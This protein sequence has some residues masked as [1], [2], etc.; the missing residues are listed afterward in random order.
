MA[1][2]MTHYLGYKLKSPIILSSGPA[3]KDSTCLIKAVEAG[4]GAVTTP[5]IR[6]E[7]MV[8]PL[9]NLAAVCGGN[10]MLNSQGHSDVSWEDW[11]KI[12][13]PETKKSGA[14][15]IAKLGYSVEEVEFLAPKV[16]AAGADV[17]EIIAPVSDLMPKMV[18][19]AKANTQLPVTAKISGRWAD[20]L[21]VA[22]AC[23]E[24]GAKAITAIDTIGPAL[25]IDIKTGRPKLGGTTRHGTGFGWLSG[26]AIHP[27]AVATVAHIALLRRV[28]VIGIGG[29]SDA[30]SAL[31]MIMAGATAVGLQTAV[32]ME[33]PSVITTILTE[34]SSLLETLGYDSLEQARGISLPYLSEEDTGRDFQIML[35]KEACKDCARNEAC[36][37]VCPYGVFE[38]PV[39]NH[40]EC[41]LECPK[42][43]LCVTKCSGEGLKV[44]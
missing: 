36:P 43:G 7:Q 5:S 10:S 15:V 1:D 4:V 33:G 39:Y 27:I 17:I 23:I 44:G 29:I 34:L 31:E 16:T 37:V 38:P 19:V 26:E 40:E 2:L 6:A 3:A 13:I 28:P 18:A 22:K 9:P 41:K 32:A 35:S 12:H 24:A 11:V 14:V 30:A 25:A 21:D 42:C 20:R 8:H